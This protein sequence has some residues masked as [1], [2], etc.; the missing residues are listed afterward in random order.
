MCV[1]IQD[2]NA[3]SYEVS[4]NCFTPPLHDINIVKIQAEDTIDRYGDV[5]NLESNMFQGWVKIPVKPLLKP[6]QYGPTVNMVFEETH[7]PG[8]ISLDET[9]LD[10]IKKRANA[11]F[12][13]KREKQKIR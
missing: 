6:L 3:S 8:N 2:Q 11:L 5:K 7:Q 13:S 1:Q 10:T 12:N 4:D 9:F